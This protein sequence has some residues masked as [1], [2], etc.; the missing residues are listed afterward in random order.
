MLKKDKQPYLTLGGL[1]LP[2][3][4]SIGKWFWNGKAREKGTGGGGGGGGGGGTGGSREGR[5]HSSAACTFDSLIEEAVVAC[6][7]LP[8]M[9]FPDT[10]ELVPLS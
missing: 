4:F 9:E 3:F 6:W 8:Q 2:V 5:V 7:Q 1:L 10:P